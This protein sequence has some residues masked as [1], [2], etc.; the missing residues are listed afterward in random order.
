[1]QGYVLFVDWKGSEE[2]G[3]LL[4]ERL[5]RELPPKKLQDYGVNTMP[6]RQ[7]DPEEGIVTFWLD[8]EAANF[9]SA[10]NKAVTFLRKAKV[11]NTVESYSVEP[12]I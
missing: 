10:K 4:Q 9:A 2:E 5:S 1:M 8:F 3:K 12:H 6:T 11:L 7:F